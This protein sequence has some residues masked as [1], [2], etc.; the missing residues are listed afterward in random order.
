[1]GEAF[2]P[3]GQVALASEAL[4]SSYKMKIKNLAQ[5]GMPDQIVLWTHVVCVWSLGT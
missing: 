4:Y 3:V 1:M 5:S 2:P